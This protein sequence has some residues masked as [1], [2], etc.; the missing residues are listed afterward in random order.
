MSLATV[1]QALARCLNTSHWAVDM[2]D[3]FC[4]NMYGYTFS[5]YTTALVHWNSMPARSKHPGDRNAPAGML[6]FWGIGQGH[7]AIA[8]G[9]GGCFS[10][11]IAGPGTVSRVPMS[12]IE[13]QWGKPYLG[14]S[15]PVFQGIEWSAA[16]IKGLDVS[17]YQPVAFDVTGSD[18]VFIKA[19]QG[20]SYVS[21]NLAGQTV[22]ARSAGLVTGFYHFQSKGS[23]AAQAKY[24]VDHLN[25]LP[26][27]VLACDW[28]TDPVT[29]TYPTTAEKD[30][31]IREVQRLAPGHKVL[32]YCNTSFWKS[33][34]T[35][36]F[37][38]DGLWIADPNHPAGAPAI[39]AP[40]RIQQYGITGGMDRNIAN[41]DSKAAMRSWAG[42]GTETEMALTAQQTFEAVWNTDAVASPTDAADHAT[43]PTWAAQTYLKD[44]D[45]QVRALRKE[46]AAFKVSAAA[47]EKALADQ[48]TA[49]TN[50]VLSLDLTGL[51][52]K[53]QTV[54][55]ETTITLHTG[56]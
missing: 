50:L 55:N 21:P 4:A 54:I 52:T 10:I 8:D 1:A 56:A 42:G 44:T 30:A 16:M 23:P 28:E 12:R 2:C 7:V 39:A 15:T 41:F 9:L 20:Q 6:L 48:L 11:D 51:E 19:T 33:I 3:N 24:F 18:F 49:L 46:F 36:S 43:N 38:G 35:S 47:A 34:D 37:S 17:S 40:W 53:L 32:L 29:K 31:F 5:G 14:W 13:T 25:L 22:H 45:A 27:D 26:G